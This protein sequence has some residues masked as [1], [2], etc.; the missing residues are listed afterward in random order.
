VSALLSASRAAFAAASFDAMLA[1]YM[2]LPATDPPAPPPAA[3]AFTCAFALRFC[4]AV[5][6]ASRQLLPVRPSMSPP[7][8]LLLTELVE[9]RRG[10]V[11]GLGFRLP[12]SP[13]PRPWSNPLGRWISCTG[14]FLVVPAALKAPLQ[15][16]KKDNKQVNVSKMFPG[17]ARVSQLQESWQVVSCT[18]GSLVVPAA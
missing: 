1:P 15:S 18:G 10:S 2:L 13:N 11:L 12:G 7:A 14:G 17:V 6:A 8:L 16:Q 4:N 5:A 9:A 3:F